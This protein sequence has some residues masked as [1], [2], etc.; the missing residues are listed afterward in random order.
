[1]KTFIIAYWSDFVG[2]IVQKLVVDFSKEKALHAF[3]VEQGWEV[4]LK[5]CGD[6]VNN[7]LTDSFVTIMELTTETSFHNTY[8]QEDIIEVK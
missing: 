5:E 1:M 6:D 4:T 2:A 8:S 7:V 3:L